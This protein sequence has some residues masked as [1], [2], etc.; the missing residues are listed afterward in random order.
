MLSSTDYQTAAGVT[1]TRHC[2]D[3]AF[4]VDLSQIAESLN[5]QRGLLLSSSYEVAGRYK[6][7]SVAAVNPPLALTLSGARFTIDAL[8]PRGEVLLPLLAAAIAPLTNLREFKTLPRHICGEIP[9]ATDIADESQRGKRPSV[10]SLLRA[11]QGIFA[12]DQDSNL[13]LYGAFGYDLVF[14]F[15]PMTLVKPRAADQRDLVLYLP[16]ELTLIDN[17]KETAARLSYEFSYALNGKNYTTQGLAAEPFAAQSPP[18]PDGVMT[19]DDLPAG[20]YAAIVRDAFARFRAGDLFEVVPSHRF[21]ERTTASPASLYQ[22]LTEL[23]PSPYGFLF[24]LGLGEYLI[25]ASPEMFVRVA[26]KRVE[27][28]PISG[29]IKRGAN[30]LEDAEQI[31]SLLNSTKDETELTMCTDVDRNDKARV[32]LPGSVKVIGR[33]QLELYSHLIH[34]VDHVEGQLAEGF[35]AL[36]AF[37][38]HMWAVTVT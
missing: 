11:I 38:S 26:G 14:Q 34:T 12:S 24:N 5:H 10:F 17:R 31:R 36:D 6:R 20:G 33:R 7:W 13:G 15:D 32:C 37:L 2:H 28:C 3:L 19:A 25:G 18:N 22:H 4:P 21:V 30:A 29:T 9:A 35:D 1:V 23:N 27:T 8:N 16:D